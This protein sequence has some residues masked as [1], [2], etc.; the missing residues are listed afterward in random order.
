MIGLG[1]MLATISGGEGAFGREA[2][3]DIGPAGS[4]FQGAEVGVGGK[5]FLVGVHPLDTSL[6]DDTLGV[7]HD[8]VVRFYAQ[9]NRQLGAGVG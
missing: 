6:V 8:H 2:E 4:L 1:A 3:Q 9:G 5:E 7:A